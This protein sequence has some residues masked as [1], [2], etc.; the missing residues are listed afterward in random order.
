MLGPI[1]AYANGLMPDQCGLMLGQCEMPAYVHPAAH[2]FGL[3]VGPMMGVGSKM[4]LVLSKD[5]I[6]HQRWH[7]QHI[8]I[9][10]VSTFGI[11]YS[12]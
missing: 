8:A 1:S 9:Y 4:G 5:G 10:N 11:W 2:Y 6:F 3:S 12:R 7:F